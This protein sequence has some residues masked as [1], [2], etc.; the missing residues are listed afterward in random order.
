M[1]KSRRFQRISTV[2]LIR[3]RI[4]S[5]LARFF[6]QIIKH[7][8]KIF[9]RIGDESDIVGEP[10][11]PKDLFQSSREE[12]R[13]YGFDTVEGLL[14]VHEDDEQRQTMINRREVFPEARLF[15]WL[16][17]IEY[18]FN[19][20]AEHFPAEPVLFHFSSSSRLLQLRLSAD[21]DILL[22]SHVLHT[23]LQLSSCIVVEH[24]LPLASRSLVSLLLPIPASLLTWRSP[25]F[26]LVASSTSR[27]WCF[28]RSFLIS[29]R[30]NLLNSKAT[31]GEQLLRRFGQ[32]W[33]LLFCFSGEFCGRTDFFNQIFVV[34]CA[35]RC[36]IHGTF[37][38]HAASLHV[39]VSG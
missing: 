6:I 5:V 8:L 28:T 29:R 25:R 3:R 21:Q 1:L 12:F 2:G 32:S 31:L 24:K 34:F 38:L 33:R 7:L 19:P 10:Q 22:A 4:L 16:R 35:G 11:V 26:L 39:L 17:R 18:P 37:G 27:W 13:T 20:L 30:I 15:H 14:E 36:R 9:S 23:V